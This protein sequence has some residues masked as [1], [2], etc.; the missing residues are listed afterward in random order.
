MAIE[1]KIVYAKTKSTFESL[2][3]NIPANLN[4]IVFIEDTK[5][6]WTCGTYFNLGYPSLLV[7]E[8]N[9]IVNITLNDSIVSL[10]ATGDGLS[11]R[12]GT[13]NRIVFNSTALSSILT[14]APL[15][16][17]SAER[18]LIHKESNVVLGTYGPTSQIE[19]AS[20]FQVPY[21]SVDKYGHIQ[22]AGTTNIG[23]RDYV[24]QRAPSTINQN[25][26]L[27]LSSNSGLDSETTS[28]EK[29]TAT[30][31]NVLGVLTIPGG[32]NVTGK[33][34]I[35]GD[36]EVTDGYIIGNLQGSVTGDA[37]PKIHADSTPKYGGAS[38]NLY[39]HVKLQDEFV[40]IPDSSSSNSNPNSTVTEKGIAASPRLV[41][42][43]K[44]GLED[45]I[46][47][48]PG[49]SII[50]GDIGVL[51]V[52]SPDKEITIKGVNGI[53]VEVTEDEIKIKGTQI[54]GFDPQGDKKTINNELTIG[55]DFITDDSNEVNIRWLELE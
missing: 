42:N 22:L 45:K 12:K 29:S 55:E 49:I 50:N 4:P 47:N 10:I 18:K 8:E 35:S 44:T 20:T 15:E 36:L 33:T 40:G 16:W 28:S 21:F 26:S 19:N 13:G 37:T 53:S 5:E 6:I 14:E 54:Y 51:I 2:K 43:T 17:L 31:N 11:I 23:I 52:D 48:K 34:N 32:L 27:L 1:S 41:W 30:Y 25:K 46:N 38:L 9:S 39:G 3:N 7:T 24:E